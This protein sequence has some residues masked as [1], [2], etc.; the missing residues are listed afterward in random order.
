[1][2]CSVELRVILGKFWW[3]GWAA[4]EQQVAQNGP[5]E[6]SVG[7]LCR[8]IAGGG[9]EDYLLGLGR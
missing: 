2:V 6:Q 4:S 1:M 5:G 9:G 7:R 8:E 3:A